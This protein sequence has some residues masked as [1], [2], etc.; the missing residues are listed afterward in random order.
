MSSRTTDIIKDFHRWSIIVLCRLRKDLAAFLGLEL[1]SMPELSSSV[2]EEEK[3]ERRK[4]LA[5]YLG[6]E[7]NVLSTILPPPP[8]PSTLRYPAKVHFTQSHNPDLQV[9]CEA[10]LTQ[11][12]NSWK[13]I[14]P[15]SLVPFPAPLEHLP[16]PKWEVD[17][18]FSSTSSANSNFSTTSS[19]SS[20]SSSSYSTIYLW[21]A[22]SNLSIKCEDSPAIF[23][24]TKC[25]PSEGRCT[26]F[27][28]RLLLPSHAFV[29]PGSTWLSFGLFKKQLLRLESVLQTAADLL[30]WSV[31][32]R[33]LRPVEFLLLS[34]T[35]SQIKMAV[36]AKSTTYGCLQGVTDPTRNNSFLLHTIPVIRVNQVQLC[37]VIQL[38]IDREH[39]HGNYRKW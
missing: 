7:E 10:H 4:N 9:S 18:A 29:A 17:S 24:H 3:K 35:S 38:I 8:P 5:S 39:N 19:S 16:A 25:S 26:Q 11:N 32:L 28:G 20:L 34:P 14:S 13:F 31:Q 33:F 22:L 1:P 30:F 12:P 36:I 27:I 23:F 6:V 21:S 37:S 15:P 2:E